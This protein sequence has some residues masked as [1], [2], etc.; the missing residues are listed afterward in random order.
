MD[1]SYPD[2]FKHINVVMI[3]L[4][5]NNNYFYFLNNLFYNPWV[6]FYIEVR[7]KF[8]PWAIKCKND[9]EAFN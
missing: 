6:K 5:S 8:I 3:S 2:Q 9:F 4:I 1:L 7:Y